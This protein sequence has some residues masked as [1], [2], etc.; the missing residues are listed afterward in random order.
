[1]GSSGKS[2][3]AS[4]HRALLLANQDLLAWNEAGRWK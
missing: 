3:Q 4:K 2:E 1:M